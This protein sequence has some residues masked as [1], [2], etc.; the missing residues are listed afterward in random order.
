MEQR[1]VVELLKI[2]KGG[3][4]KRDME[5]C[6][7]ALGIKEDWFIPIPLE[8]GSRKKFYVLDNLKILKYK[9]SIT[10]D[11]INKAKNMKDYEKYGF[12]KEDMEIIVCTLQERQ[13]QYNYL[14]CLIEGLEKEWF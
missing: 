1:K 9:F 6:C 4:F 10:D 7:K 2:C 12:S 11:Y 13:K 3:V 14:F 5:K 8:E